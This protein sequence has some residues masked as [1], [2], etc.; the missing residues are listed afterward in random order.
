MA[1]NVTILLSDYQFNK[2]AIVNQFLIDSGLSGKLCVV[3]AEYTDGPENEWSG[4]YFK[5]RCLGLE[6]LDDKSH[7]YYTLKGS[8][9]IK[10]MLKEYDRSNGHKY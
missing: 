4:G 2:C 6:A 7:F 9:S 8:E 3:L 1:N 5:R 10:R